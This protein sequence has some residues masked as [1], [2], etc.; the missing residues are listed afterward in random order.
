MSGVK[1]WKF[2]HVADIQVGSPR[3]F[4]FA[5]AWNE[6]WQ[7]ARQQIMALH[8]D[9]L[10]VGGDLTRDGNIHDF[11]M[12]AVKADFDALP[13]PCRVVPGNM[14]TGNK[15]AQAESGH[16]DGRKDLSLNVTSEQMAH[17]E[18]FFGPVEWTFVHKQVRFSGFY[19]ALAGSGLPEEARMWQW[20]EALADLPPERHHVMMMH[21]A[22]FIDD[23][24]EPDY[25]ITDRSQY[26]AWYFGIDRPHRN[27]IM[28]AFKRAGVDWVISGHI[29]CRKRDVVDGI[30]FYKA[31]ATCFPQFGERWSEGDPTLGF[32]EFTVTDSGIRDRFVPLARLSDAKGYGPGG[33]PGPELRDY[34][35]AWEK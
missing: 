13:F 16:A 32:L 11:E 31:P 6:N 30:T 7:T 33:H 10:L 25:G 15:H 1:E 20:I 17:F 3:S 14:D 8:P 9:L 12:V 4:R 22:L 5:P 26:N 18:S 27:R 34:S 35:I 29:H 21:Y 19:A 28:T 23:I 2:I 24:N